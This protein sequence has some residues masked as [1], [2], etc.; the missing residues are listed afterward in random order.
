M[1]PK[2]IRCSGGAQI[3]NSN[4]GAREKRRIFQAIRKSETNE[5]QKGIFKNEPIA[6]HGET[7]ETIR[8][9][10]MIVMS[11]GHKPLNARDLFDNLY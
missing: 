3:A 9:Q 11:D 1:R 10:K 6:I 5:P 2:K 7:V 4:G 8:M